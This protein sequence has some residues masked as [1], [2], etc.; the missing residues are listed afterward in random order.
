[1]KTKKK[2]Q[3][4][5]IGSAGKSDYKKRGAASARMEALAEAVGA[6]LAQA[7]AIVVTGGKDGIMEAAAKGAKDAGGC[8]VGVVKGPA[9]GTSNRFTDVEVVSGMEASGMDELL[10]AFMS[11]A[12][13]AIG[14]GAGTLQEIAIA[15]RNAKPVVVLDTA[16]G[17]GKRVP[18][19]LDL[20]RTVRIRRAKTPSEAVRLALRLARS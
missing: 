14:G 17:W 15:Y 20:R 3:I 9:R 11:D 7:G 8:T 12:L 18:A 2:S 10:I 16:D 4:A 13:I 1:M 5:V 6:G 19:Y